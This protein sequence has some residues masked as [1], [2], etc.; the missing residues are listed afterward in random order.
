MITS[1]LKIKDKVFTSLVAQTDKEKEM[2]LMF[3]PEPT[4]IMCFP[5]KKRDLSFWMKN[6][7]ARLDIIFCCDG[8]I[9]SI[10]YG[11]PYSTN[12]IHGGES[13]LVI[14]MPFGSCSKFNFKVG[15]IVVLG[16]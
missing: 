3:M 15:D 2:G 7:P 9:K 16:E 5:Y 4:P 10:K 11:E 13:D 1:K 12:L 14:E 6:T 8:K